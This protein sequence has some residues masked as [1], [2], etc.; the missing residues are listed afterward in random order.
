MATDGSTYGDEQQS[1]LSHDGATP[2]PSVPDT[3]EK[4]SGDSSAGEDSTAWD[5]PVEYPHGA[6]LVFIIIA[7]LMAVLLASLDQV[8]DLTF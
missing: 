2:T 1:T 3:K 7:V 6:T 5:T 4:A 8:S